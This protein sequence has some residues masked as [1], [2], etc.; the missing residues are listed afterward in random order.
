M[1]AAAVM[2]AG[3]SKDGDDNPQPDEECRVVSL[4]DNW[5]FDDVT[6]A[7]DG[8]GRITKISGSVEAFSVIST[9]TYQSNKIVA[10]THDDGELYMTSEFTLNG[11]GLVTSAEIEFSNGNVTTIEYSYV[12]GFLTKKH[13]SSVSASDFP[14]VQYTAD[15][16]YS[17]GNLTKTVSD[18]DYEGTTN[19]SYDASASYQP[20]TSY[21]QA[22]GNI[23]DEVECVLYETGYLGK[24]PKNRV[25]SDGISSF[26]YETG[27]DGKVTRIT[28]DA[29]EGYST[30]DTAIGWKCD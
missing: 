11:S 1:T 22:F 23:F 28:V 7:Y 18:A 12:D 4:G 20:F 29:P 6:F 25:T 17:N 24:L 30:Y 26:S 19:I 13:A 27:S 3:C 5:H 8:Q 16:T 9:V 14:D 21:Y 15:L 2:F 10:T